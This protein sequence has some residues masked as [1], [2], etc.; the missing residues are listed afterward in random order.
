MKSSVL[1]ELGFNSV[2]PQ[3]LYSVPYIFSRDVTTL[4]SSKYDDLFVCGHDGMI[5]VQVLVSWLPRSPWV[6]GHGMSS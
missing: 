4:M 5:D 3:I 2:T 6:D 1:V